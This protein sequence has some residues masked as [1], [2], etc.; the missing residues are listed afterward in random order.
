MAAI[1]GTRRNDR[2]VGTRLDDTLQGF[3]GNDSLTGGE[4]DD[5]LRGDAGNDSLVGGA[6]D[7]RLA[8]GTGA[9]LLDG[10]AGDDQLDGGDGRDDLR[11]GT[12]DDRYLPDDPR[13]IA[14]GRLDPGIDEVRVSFSYTLGP[15]Q[16]R[17]VLLG[18]A[19]LNGTGNGRDN[20]L[21]GN[22]AAN[23]LLGGAGDDRLDAGAG[24]DH[25]DGGAGAD[26]LLG[27]AGN[28]VLV[29]DPADLLI[30]G[31]T[32]SDTLLANR[33]GL[34][35]TAAS[36][37]VLRDIDTL[38]L[39]GGGVQR[40]SFDASD[41]FRLTG[42]EA[43]TVRADATDV[44]RVSGEWQL[45]GD[46][47]AG[48]VTYHRFLAEGGAEL[49]V[50]RGSDF[51]VGAFRALHDLG[52][53][54]GFH[55]TL[56]TGASAPVTQV[57]GAGDVNGDG[58][59][60]LLVSVRLTGVGAQQPD[61]AYLVFGGAA[62]SPVSVALESL[63]GAAGARFVAPSRSN[64]GLSVSAA[65]DV[66]GDGFADLL[67]SETQ[68]TGGGARLTAGRAWLVYGHG[69]PFPASIDLE[70]LSA[71]SAVR[72]E[73]DSERAL[74]GYSADSA[75][76]VNGD[77]LADA[78]L[79]PFTIIGDPIN[80]RTGATL[81]MVLLGNT[82]GLPAVTRSDELDGH[83]GFRLELP[84]NVGFHVAQVSSAGDFNGDGYAD[85]MV[86]APQSNLG[87]TPEPVI[88]LVFGHA[89][90]FGPTV[91]LDSLDGS[92]GFALVADEDSLGFVYSLNV[93]SAGDINGDGFDDLVIGAPYLSTAGAIFGGG[94]FV[95]FGHGGATQ[96]TFDLA[97]LD[98]G[99]GFRIQGATPGARVGMS[100]A[101]V[102]DVNG[103]G[104][105]D[106]AISSGHFGERDERYLLFGGAEFD[107]TLVLDALDGTRG[108]ALVSEQPGFSDSPVDL[109]GAGDL[110]G[111][112]FDDLVYEAL[113]P[114]TSAIAGVLYGRD[115]NATATRVGG[116]G[117]DAFVGTTAADVLIGGAGDD[118]L[119]GRG[120][121]DALTGGAGDDVLVYAADARRLSGD[122]GTD[123][124]RIDGADT[125]LDL[126]GDIARRLEGFERIDLRGSGN[127]QVT[128]N[129]LA[130][131]NLS[132]S[133]NL[134]RI[135]GDTGDAVIAGG[136][137]LDAGA[138]LEQGTTY[139]R[140]IQ[141]EA[142]L[143]VALSVDRGGVGVVGQWLDARGPSR[144]LEGGA[145]DDFYLV[146]DAQ[147][148]VSEANGSG[149]D[150][151]RAWLSF[152]LPEGVEILR[153][154]GND[155]LDGTGAGANE[156][157]FGNA[158]NNH[159]D[160]G[161][162]SDHL[163]AGVGDDRLVFDVADSLVDGGL[164]EDTLVVVTPS[165]VDFTTQSLGA[166]ANIELLALGNGGLDHVLLDA[167]HIVAMTDARGTLRITGDA[168]DLLSVAGGWAQRVSVIVNGVEYAR[169]SRGAATLL[170]APQV[171]VDLSVTSIEL[172]ALSASQG[173]HLQDVRSGL[174]G[175]TLAAAG[176][177]NGDGFEDF[178]VGEPASFFM[179]PNPSPA[180][181]T[182]YV[183]FGRDGGVPA[184]LDPTTLDGTNGFRLQSRLTLDAAASLR[185]GGAGDVNGDGYDDVVLTVWR[186]DA[187][188]SDATSA[189]VVF[190]KGETFAASVDFAAADGAMGTRYQG[191]Q[192]VQYFRAHLS[193]IATGIGDFD[194]DG[195]AD[196]ALRGAVV[197]DEDVA[198]GAIS[199]MFGQGDPYPASQQLGLLDAGRRLQ[200]EPPAG[201]ALG[202][203][204]RVRGAGDLNGDGITDLALGLPNNTVGYGYS[205]ARGSSFLIFGRAAGFDAP[206]A[207][208]A[209]NGSD[210]VRFN[211]VNVSDTSGW[212]IDSA[213]DFN[214]DGIDD[215]LIGASGVNTPDTP[216]VGAV[217]VVFGRRDGFDAVLDLATLDGSDGLRIV[218]ASYYSRIGGAVAGVGDVNGDG[219]D[220]L[221]ISDSHIVHPGGGRVYLLFGAA[222]GFGATVNLGELPEGA[223]LR[224]DGGVLTTAGYAVSAVGDFDGDGFDDFMIGEPA[225]WSVGADVPR[226][227]VVFGRDFAG[228]ALTSGAA[229]E[230][231]LG[232]AGDDRLVAGGGGDVVDGGAGSD[233]LKGGAGDDVLLYDAADRRIEGD[234]GVD[235]LRLDARVG[236]LDLTASTGPRVTGIEVIDLGPG[237]HVLTLDGIR[238]GAL[239]DSG[240]PLRVVGDAGDAV[241]ASGAWLDA[242]LRSV[243]GIDYARYVQD[244]FELRVQ[245][246]IDRGGVAVRG[247]LLEGGP[248]D[249]V[250]DGGAGADELRGAGGLNVLRGGGGDDLYV[251]EQSGDVIDELP[252]GGIDTVRA[253][254]DYMLPDE[255]ERLVLVSQAGLSGTGN[256]LANV[257][258]GST[259]DD[260]LDGG[261]GQDSMRGGMGD[262][263]LVFE[264]DDL[265]LDGGTGYDT[266]ALRQG[267]SLDLRALTAGSLQSIEAITLE[268]GVA[269]VLELDPASVRAVVG[270]GGT[271]RINGDATDVVRGPG[272]WAT[273]SDI[274]VGGT[275][276]HRYG[277]ENVTLEI[278][279][280]VDVDLV[281]RRLS[282]GHLDGANG[283][284]VDVQAPHVVTMAG[285]S[286]GDFDGDGFDDLVLGRVGNNYGPT[287]PRL[288]VMFGQ[289][290]RGD[291]LFEPSG[292][293][294]PRVLTI[295]APYALPSVDRI[296][297]FN[298]DGLADIVVGAPYAAS[299]AVESGGAAF[300]IY[301]RADARG[302]S[303][304][305]E[306]LDSA[307]GFR[308]DG[309]RARDGVGTTVAD[310]GDLNGDGYADLVIGAR[311]QTVDGAYAAGA[312]Y[313]VFGRPDA[314]PTSLSLEALDGR[315]G[316]RVDGRDRFDGLGTAV[317]P[318]GDVNGDGFDDLLL[319][320]PAPV[321]G[322]D[323]DPGE[324]AVIFGHA[325]DFAPELRPDDLDGGNGFRLVSPADNFALGLSLG[326]AGDMNGDGLA[327]FFVVARDD[328]SGNGEVFVVFGREGA[329]GATFDLAT[330]DGSNGLRITKPD[331]FGG[332]VSAAGDV[333]GDGF[334]DL[335]VGSASPG[336][337]WFGGSFLI[338][339]RGD[340]FAA[341]LDVTALDGTD[342][343]ALS[344]TPSQSFSSGT[345]VANAGDLDGD[346][347]D[348]VLIG[349]QGIGAQ[350][351]VVFGR[352]FTLASPLRGDSG[353][354]VLLGGPDDEVLIGAQGDDH[355][356]GGGGVDVLIG[357]AGDDVL[358]VDGLD[359][360]A[361]GDLG[362]DTL[363]LAGTA[364][365]LDLR[366]SG[367]QRHTG[368][369]RI[370]LTG[371]GANLLTIDRQGVAAQSERGPRLWISG[372][373]DDAVAAGDD[374]LEAGLLQADGR[375]FAR[376]VQGVTELLVETAIERGAIGVAGVMRTGGAASDTLL[377][378]AGDDLLEGGGGADQMEGGAGDD[379]YIVDD[380][381]DTIIEV[382]DGGQDLVLSRVD[383]ALPAHL[384][385]LHLVGV[386]PVDGTGNEAANELRGNDAANRLDGGAGADTLLGGAGDDTLVL[387]LADTRIDGGSGVDTLAVLDASDFSLA[388]LV[389]AQL[390]GVEA[391]DLVNGAANDVSL[392]AASILALGTLGATLRLRA[393]DA[394]RI[395]VAGDWTYAANL[396]LDGAR[397]RSFTRDG[398]TLQVADGAELDILVS[399]VSVG[400]LDGVNGFAVEHR[401]G[402]HGFGNV[403]AAAGDV[404]GDGFDDFLL[405]A[406]EAGSPYAAG[407]TYVVFGGASGAPARVDVTTLNGGNGF[408]LRGATLRLQTG[409][410]V[411]PAG[412]VNGDGVDDLLIASPYASVGG[413]SRAGQVFVVFGS[414]AGFAAEVSLA[415]LNGTNGF[416]LDGA[417]AFEHS[418]SR[419]AAAGDVNGDGFGDILVGR[420]GAAPGGLEFAGGAY[421]VFGHAGAF[422]A[423][424]SIG[425]LNGRNGLRLQG[426]E[427]RDY[428]G[429]S[430]A[431]VGDING[432]GF[433][434]FAVNASP[435]YAGPSASSGFVLFGKAGGFPAN[436]TL[437]QPGNAGFELVGL[438]RGPHIT[439]AAAG[440]VNGDGLDDLLVSSLSSDRSTY[441]VFGRTGGFG[442]SV[443]LSALD[444]VS[445]FRLTADLSTGLYSG[446]AVNGVGDFNGDGFDDL[447][448]GSPSSV[449]YARGAAYVVFGHGG[450]F[451]ATLDVTTLDGRDGLRVIGAN[452][453]DGIGRSVSGAGD[454]NG[455]GFDD[456]LVG[457]S[458]A[459][460]GSQV[461]GSG[462]AY[463]V[464]GHAP[465]ATGV[466]QGGTGDDPLTGS[467]A[468]ERLLGGAGADLLNGAGGA[469]VL[470]GGAGDDVLVFDAAD[471]RL[472]GGNGRDT[473]RLDASG[474]VLDLTQAG[475][476]RLD[477][478]ERIDLGG[479]G[480]TLV[481]DVRDVLALPD[482]NA[483]WLSASARQLLVTGEAG[484]TVQSLGQGWVRGAD[485]V[486]DGE[487][488]ASFT[489][490]GS[491]AQLLVDLDLTRQVS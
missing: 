180:D 214:G 74:R 71:T 390:A 50:E 43:L 470:L 244:G 20:H 278:E 68:G 235:T 343:L 135:D 105:D 311:N 453:L 259:G 491:S 374:W 193:D 472:D 380:V 412:D 297:D 362:I 197:N 177:V 449:F 353:D 405:G 112:G 225:F 44:L 62:D 114:A 370:D 452:A 377:G 409:E 280:S 29:Y 419:V 166:V 426:A 137:W 334:D 39:R 82:D 66:N 323:D 35:L 27:G 435:R 265:L 309:I 414:R 299:G 337:A 220:D 211:G 293:D 77:G 407:E 49:R 26:R 199:V 185:V 108:L 156:Q 56:D 425:A 248:G 128:L 465:D 52:A 284:T 302:L 358:V 88:F 139:Q 365:A 140:Y 440:D 256:G 456:L 328:L 153:L 441:V 33:A 133:T 132:T 260:L 392:D 331:R 363:R 333:N 413:L 192:P 467:V 282:L 120:G 104:F 234:R 2:L 6:G 86:Y 190:G 36:L 366:A 461:Y 340:G 98:G 342:G 107:A 42:G 230:T 421:L 474:L 487:S 10:G 158:G 388:T 76:D 264:P 13:E 338:F 372:D 175:I 375:E 287:T 373:A 294:A 30:D 247:L 457:S 168:G 96:A 25:L 32:G 118:L 330:L 75:G 231:L 101:R 376:Y 150:T 383:Y 381:G 389:Q 229:G 83:N 129:P 436:L 165:V 354:D 336:Y 84:E 233:V 117:A 81:G 237:G 402:T 429:Q 102:G 386:L 253:G 172:A 99:N 401:P 408:K 480:N 268:D 275:T 221:L 359:R 149:Q 305:L 261:A 398:A 463:V 8:G 232:T 447:V 269:A 431:G 384:E 422:P 16:E 273:L 18:G 246:A 361:H 399:A 40:L 400:V 148:S 94:A 54:R 239:T 335:L 301:G 171:N 205:Y 339:G 255:V 476:P 121:G 14:V 181:A 92:D 24:H 151:L 206:L 3:E 169:Y 136:G 314:L 324:V 289:D 439:V 55:L 116:V 191:A 170:V 257:L 432:D 241:L 266:V 350:G 437:G 115:F 179:S 176:D 126:T 349:S 326:D 404:N 89:E 79:G 473:L 430:V 469:D 183:I 162:G 119:D 285:A 356:T 291:A 267:V 155:A 394:D 63:D 300:V 254:V 51:T 251:I 219:F 187:D 9:D 174:L 464:Y 65:G 327:D 459:G 288:Y 154:A 489:V 443:D 236:A 263:R 420:P 64:V 411:G 396:E 227:H 434:D 17:L 173:F 387:D 395:T 145:G 382:A 481:L 196:L 357:G 319:G 460:T 48:G 67:L 73:G 277:A 85:A 485:R 306:N 290:Q 91:S 304:D 178:I 270:A 97:S 276:F 80:P 210:G 109:R 483:A 188:D 226:A 59:D 281:L 198:G 95:V 415:T 249:D 122:A 318:A 444:G 222:G 279:A 391:L 141:G 271:L 201:V 47:V 315:N 478:I 212:S 433:D 466:V 332:V 228:G 23:R 22:T 12:G 213:G 320:A 325:G 403:L 195:Y 351:Y 245:T 416:R 369:E 113:P 317:S 360:R 442:A 138:I 28:D 368:F 484:D 329:F 418:G 223:A 296:G 123:T 111:D 428:S 134:L 103:D 379:T 163:S 451:A 355:L 46:L 100:V 316:F 224:F 164:G 352:D 157:L 106:L 322:A 347:F 238:V 11:G 424:L 344:G 292:T 147:D 21:L 321:F 38:D 70:A 45:Q 295:S 397:Y 272:G 393:D 438:T 486:L 131:L 87:P 159:L 385:S 144:A 313:V 208:D 167:A 127:H 1:V 58:Y 252:G 209:L 310:A 19:A 258:D 490:A 307:S 471:L 477:G 346:G 143:R 262:D 348:D 341:T 364:L 417:T 69:G 125:L 283:F 200:I 110:N 378:G 488:Y 303:L 161:A 194:A 450:A 31:G 423:S 160:G 446:T 203:A 130:L 308:L 4:G 53:A 475:G 298:G 146:D 218:G 202:Q 186:A 462:E 41:L 371:A 78:L 152:T 427:A 217:Y 445:G 455:D 286:V 7:D 243:D 184:M 312:S 182:A 274:T 367:A 61:M 60:D 207:L 458:S 410:A 15:H 5:L 482:G 242:G 406:P 454:V 37:S 93:D 142:E 204:W 124:L 345:W 215:L 90:G 250:L 34:V 189:Y 72:V 448:I 57:S 216:G 240:M 479:G 468:D